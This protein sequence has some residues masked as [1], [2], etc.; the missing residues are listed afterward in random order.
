MG[1]DFKGGAQNRPSVVP[2]KPHELPP[3]SPG[4]DR[5]RRC[6]QAYAWVPFSQP[7][8]DACDLHKTHV[9]TLSDFLYAIEAPNFQKVLDLA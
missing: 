8:A 2:Q 6:R 4:A 5:F 1:P 9:A 3:P 7:R